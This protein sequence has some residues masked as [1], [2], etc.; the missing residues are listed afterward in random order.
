MNRKYLR[1]D[2]GTKTE[3]RASFAQMFN[4]RDLEYNTFILFTRAGALGFNLQ[5]ADRVVVYASFFLPLH[6]LTFACFSFESD[7]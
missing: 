5:T 2:G 3:E 6:L 4:A 1:R 7:W